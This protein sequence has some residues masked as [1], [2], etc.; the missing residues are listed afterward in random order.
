MPGR[1]MTVTGDPHN[2]VVAIAEDKTRA[3]TG[4]NSNAGPHL[5]TCAVCGVKFG[6]HKGRV[7]TAQYC[8]MRCRD[9]GKR[10]DVACEVCGARG[11]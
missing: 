11:C 8:S 1:S 7:D 9:S 5:K 10:V 4:R 2:G 6:V 3:R